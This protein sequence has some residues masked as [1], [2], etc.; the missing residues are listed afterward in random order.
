VYKILK[1]ITKDVKVT[2]H[3]QGNIHENVFLWYYKNLWN[4]TNINELQLEF[5]LTDYSHAFITI[6]ELEKVL[7]LTKNGKTPGQDNI[8][9][10][11]YKYAPQ[12]FKLQL[13]KF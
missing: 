8:N 13:L 7:K 5:N 12:E 2:T 1:Q 9:S 6:D 4:T 3:I 11:L 10:E